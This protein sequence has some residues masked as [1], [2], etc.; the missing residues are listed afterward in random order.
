MHYLTS[1]PQQPSE[2]DGVII[3]ILQTEKVETGE[4]QQLVQGHAGAGKWWS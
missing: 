1:F 4:G 2:V 3:P